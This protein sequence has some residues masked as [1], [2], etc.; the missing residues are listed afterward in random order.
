M[1]VLW[2]GI[3]SS[4]KLKAAFRDGRADV[5]RSRE[6]QQ[7]MPS[8]GIAL[9]NRQSFCAGLFVGIPQCARARDSA[10]LCTE[11]LDSLHFSGKPRRSSYKQGW[12]GYAALGTKRS[13]SL[14]QEPL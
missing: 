9:L 3:G 1:K 14:S 7:G 11:R 6:W 8:A 13:V 10:R 5:L 2:A 4:Y 12:F